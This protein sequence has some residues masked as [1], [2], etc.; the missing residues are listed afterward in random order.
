MAFHHVMG[1]VAA[2]LLL[3]ASSP[4]VADTAVLGRKGGAMTDDDAVEGEATMGPGRY[5]VILDAG[6]TGTRVHVFRFDKK[7]DLLKIGDDIE[8]FAKV[9]IT[10]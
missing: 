9:I 1:I 10:L 4:A 5:A 6:S 3:M 7:I 2:M 8:V